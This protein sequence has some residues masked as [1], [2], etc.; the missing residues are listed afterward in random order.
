LPK[1]GG[2]GNPLCSLENSNS[3]L[4]FADSENRTVHKKDFSI[5]YIEPKSVQFWLVLLKFGCYGNSL[6]SLK[7]SDCVFEF[8][9]PEDPTLHALSVSI[10]CKE[11]KSV[12]F[13]LIFA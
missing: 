13:W 8:A 3:I 12:Q 2:H 4:E 1:F 10:S 6:S 9:D 5:S 11:L 7:I